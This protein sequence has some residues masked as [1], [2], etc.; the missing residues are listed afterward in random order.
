MRQHA[1]AAAGLVFAAR[2]RL[3]FDPA[4]FDLP[5]RY[6][7]MRHSPETGEKL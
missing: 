3:S 7:A 5:S 1:A 6:P 4:D 2:E